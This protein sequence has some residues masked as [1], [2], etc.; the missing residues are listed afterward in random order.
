MTAE[1]SERWGA[2]DNTGM[3]AD[4]A[5]FGSAG[6]FGR[7]V[8][9]ALT[10]L[11]YGC[12]TI[13]LPD[14]SRHAFGH[15]DGTGPY[16]SMAVKHRRAFRRFALGGDLGLAASYI[17]GDWT[18]P[19]LTAVFSVAIANENSPMIW[20]AGTLLNRAIN[21][22]KHLSRTNTRRGSRRNIA[23]HYD[24]GNAFYSKWLDPT[25]TYSSAYYAD[26]SMSLEQ[27]QIAKYDRILE[28]GEIGPGHRVLEVGSG[29]GGFAC[30]AA[31]RGAEVHGI[32]VSREQLAHS[33]EK[34]GRS[35]AAVP[36]RF[37]FMDYRDVRGTY[38][39]IV[40]IE[41]LEAVGERNW[42]D[43]FA[44]LRDRLKPGGIATVQ[45][46]TI[47]DERFAAY[48][49]GADFIQRYIFPGGVLLSPQIMR[50]LSDAA[51]LVQEET[52]FFRLSYARTLAEW[53]K[54]FQNAWP[55]VAELG[56]DMPF[57]RM[58]EYYL[59]YCEAGFK[60][61]NIDVGL[62]KIRRPA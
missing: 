8:L 28:L 52:E 6:L 25:M 20:S 36:P 38:D 50:R 43:Y 62:F 60:A 49:K 12:L 16:A 23:Y 7:L 54:R 61:G 10:R 21:R 44:M 18:S 5:G 58:W 13:T 45:V 35:N 30:H 56:F 37:T 55:D 1:K 29:W 3:P 31:A 15:A 11:E 22:V 39:R 59:S 33:Q 40:S 14:G 27:A 9:N 2:E 48:R 32:T 24:L 51:G 46:I 47:D 19:D 34:A 41:M 26:P 4:S 17:D 42:P 57:K 53:N